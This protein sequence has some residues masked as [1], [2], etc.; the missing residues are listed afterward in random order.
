MDLTKEEWIVLSALLDEAL[1][2]PQVQRQAWLDAR[3]GISTHMRALAS[4]MLS[5]TDSDYSLPELPQYADADLGA[6][7]P[8]QAQDLQA[9]GLVGPYRLLREIGHGGMGTVWLATRDDAAP[10]RDVALKLPHST[11]RQH[12][13]AERFARERD[14]LAA[15][16]H[17]HIARLYDA[18]VTPEG[19][20]F[21]ALEYVNGEP[22]DRYCTA[23]GLNIEAR[24][25]LFLQVMDAVQYAHSQLVVHR[26]LKPAN[27]L[28][29]AD[30]E[31]RLLDFGVAKLLTD[32]QA[33]ET[34]LTQLGGRALTPQYA[35]PEQILG[36]TIST[37]VDVYALGVMLYELL[38]GV[39]PYRPKRD[40]RGA[41]EEAIVETEAVAPSRAPVS[42]T[43]TIGA[44]RRTL[45]GD[46]DTIILKALKKDPQSRY[47]TVAAFADD[48]QRFING[49]AVLAQPDSRLY[50]AR[51][52]LQRNRWSVAGA[53]VVVMSLSVGLGF[54]LWQARLAQKE[55]HTAGAVKEFMQGIFLANSGQQND[56]LRARQTTA[57]ELLDIG[58]TKLDTALDEA[59]EA[60]LEILKMFSELYS[61][62]DLPERALGFAQ[63]HA[64]LTRTVY[65]TNSS[66]LIE[67]LLVLVAALRGSDPDD[68][69]IEPALNEAGNILERQKNPANDLVVVHAVLAAEYFADRDFPKALTYSHRAAD[70]QRTATDGSD[71]ATVMVRAARVDFQAGDCADAA[72]TAAE[73]LVAADASTA[74]GEAGNGGNMTLASLQEVYGRAAWCQGDLPS[75]E[76]HLRAAVQSAQKIFGDDDMETVRITA[77]LADFLM[78]NRPGN[79]GSDLLSHAKL[80]LRKHDADH[81]SRL[82]IEALAAM[83]HT[84]LRAR[85]NALAL[86]DLSQALKLRSSVT[87]SPAVAE[88]LRDQ[89]RALLALQRPA[90]A[91]QAL[92]R[93]KAMR[94]K[95][96][97]KNATLEQEESA[98]RNQIALLLP[99]GKL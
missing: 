98:L 53:S 32:G 99:P 82:Y 9:G 5:S 79:E 4:R 83:G 16:V 77:R 68:A 43:T 54:S 76:K 25:K 72:K 39:L 96:G 35:A 41:L 17:P 56:P 14:I 11:L 31:V 12:H 93:A 3:D 28:V 95:S 6:L 59:P 78:A 1:E 13:L 44:E 57:R 46:L 18:G 50:R 84:E 75:A 51:K 67:A 27:V 8:E 52:F 73:G 23:Q 10:K 60:K 80:T 45:R 15:L 89:S 88:M 66:Q 30:G 69:R 62:L 55:A 81:K 92:E 2:L 63:Q 48:L 19:R 70:L 87:A 26:D 49:E 34:E 29:T 86:D 22:V 64:T 71:V 58:S 38:T 61:Q 37:A 21:L 85:Q 74:K 91:A 47:T 90:D 40:S 24:L 65:G 36:Q 20:P 7:L 42:A 33:Q 94:E 97:I